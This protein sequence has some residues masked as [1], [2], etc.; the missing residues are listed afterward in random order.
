MQLNDLVNLTNKHLAGEQFIYSELRN[1]FDSVVDE[2]N[3]RLNSTFPSFSEFTQANYPQ[4]P[5]YNFFPDKYIR[6]VVSVGAAF[7]FYIEDEEGAEGAVK[8]EEQYQK[9]LFYMERDYSVKVPEEF[10]ADDQ[11]HLETPPKY[12]FSSMYDDIF[13]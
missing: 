9:N 5:N 6:S 10:Q 11:G 13:S 2:I 1:F 4:H 7:H 8:Y 12:G 3:H